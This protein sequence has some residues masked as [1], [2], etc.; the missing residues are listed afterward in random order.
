MSMKSKALG[1]LAAVVVIVLIPV[2]DFYRTSSA[3]GHVVNVQKLSGDVT[4]HYQITLTTT[5]DRVM[6]F[7]N[8]D[9]WLYFKINSANVQGRAADA[10]RTNK[11][12]RISYYGWRSNL[13]GWFW[14]ALSV[15]ELP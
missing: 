3:E 13:F 15:T 6:V 5:E 10:E 14:N 9:T 12:V 7:R 11:M 1:I 4:P 8:D 2:V